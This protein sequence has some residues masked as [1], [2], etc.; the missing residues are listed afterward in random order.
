MNSLQTSQ[1]LE[2]LRQ[3]AAI[4]NA[5]GEIRRQHFNTL[6]TATK[7]MLLEIRA[8]SIGSL[9]IAGNARVQNH[10]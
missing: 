3:D 2:Q 7:T 5:L 9:E 10:V 4:Q 6:L 8:L 1:K